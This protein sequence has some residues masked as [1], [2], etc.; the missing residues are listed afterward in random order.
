M[1]VFKWWAPVLLT[2]CEKTGSHYLSSTGISR[3]PR[4]FLKV[5]GFKNLSSWAPCSYQ[6]TWPFPSQDLR[7]NFFLELCLYQTISLLD[8]Y[9]LFHGWWARTIFV[10]FFLIK[11]KTF[12]LA[13]RVVCCSHQSDRS[14]GYVSRSNQ[15]SAFGYV[16]RTN[17]VTALGYVSHQSD[18]SIG[19]CLHQSEYEIGVL[20]N[21][22]MEL[23]Q[24]ERAPRMTY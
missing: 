6:R 24:H 8:I 15:I 14:I 7:M 19:I 12:M 2:H 4:E 21:F 22:A 23:T 1:L 18:H 16:S 11:K 17:K 5:I 3:Q 10:F 13:Y 20:Q 9:N